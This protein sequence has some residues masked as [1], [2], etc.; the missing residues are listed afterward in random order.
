M[1]IPHKKSQFSDAI[2]ETTHTSISRIQN[3]E[4][5]KRLDAGEDDKVRKGEIIDMVV[6]FYCKHNKIK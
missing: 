1:N 3:L 5:L 4:K 2:K 6:E